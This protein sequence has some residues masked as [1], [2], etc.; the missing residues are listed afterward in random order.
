[1]VGHGNFLKKWKHEALMLFPCN[2]NERHGIVGTWR[3]SNL[4][5]ASSEKKS[6]KFHLQLRLYGLKKGMIYCVEGLFGLC[7]LL[8]S[9]V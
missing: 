3:N 8:V 6:D 1:V 2:L 5:K 9:H 4:A 7:G